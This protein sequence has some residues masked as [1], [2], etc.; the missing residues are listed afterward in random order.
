MNMES[1]PAF[2]IVITVYNI[3]EYIGECIESILS[4][5]FNDFE[6]I[7]VDDCSSDNSYNILKQYED[8]DER[9]HVYRLEKN[10]GLASARNFGIKKSCGDYIYNIDGDD[11]LTENALEIMYDLMKNNNLDVLSFSALSFFDDEKLKEFG[12]E[13]E[14]LRKNEYKGVW[15][16]KD[17]FAELIKNGDRAVGNMVLYCF[18][19]KFIK[20]N[21]LYLEEGLRYGDDRMFNIFMK[22]GRVMCINTPL[23]LRRYREGSMITGGM[24]KVY[25]ESLIVGLTSELIVWREIDSNDYIN[26]QIEKYFDMR[27]REIYNLE[28]VFKYDKSEMKYLENYKV[29]N[30]L[31]KRITN[32]KSIFDG[33]LSY[34]T[35][36]SIKKEKELY[37]YGIGDISMKVSRVLEANSIK[38]FSYVVSKE[39]NRIFNN[40]K[41]YTIDEISKSFNPFF[42]IATSKM[43]SDEIQSNLIERGF[44]RYCKANTL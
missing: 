38:D 11:K 10:V 8:T 17:F 43:Y 4:Q 14:Y 35:I 6:L 20:D 24:K 5:S 37:V 36:E 33:I 21:N 22:A 40:R 42:I 2:S 26:S 16:G 44:N 27:L 12:D 34:E 30:Y 31:Y 1:S 13:K 15:K 25:L 32:R 28:Q 19:S 29:E 23:Y 7:C 41:V 3:E 39:S 18:N 9:I